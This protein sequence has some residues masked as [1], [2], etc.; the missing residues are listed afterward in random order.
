MSL[1][2]I[3]NV[4]EIVLQV[5]DC[6]IESK[7]GIGIAT[8]DQIFIEPDLSSDLRLDREPDHLKQDSSILLGEINHL[9]MINSVNLVST[10]R[11]SYKRPPTWG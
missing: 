5:F 7:T 4:T 6:E 2:E 8:F 1:R 11:K 3:G 10:V 9:L